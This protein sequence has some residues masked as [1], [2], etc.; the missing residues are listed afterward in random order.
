[1][2]ARVVLVVVVFLAGYLAGALHVGYLEYQ[3]H[4]QRLR[5]QG[6]MVPSPFGPIRGPSDADLQESQTLYP[7][8]QNGA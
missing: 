4:R 2:V 6:P 1:M 7:G 5:T 3:R 8:G